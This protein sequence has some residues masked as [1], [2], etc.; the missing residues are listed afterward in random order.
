MIANK[1]AFKSKHP[2]D[3]KIH[4]IDISMSSTLFLPTNISNHF[5]DEKNRILVYN[6]SCKHSHSPRLDIYFEVNPLDRKGSWG[7]GNGMFLMKK[8]KSFSVWIESIMRERRTSREGE[9]PVNKVLLIHFLWNVVCACDLLI[10]FR[11]K[12]QAWTRRHQTMTCI[13]VHER[14]FETTLSPNF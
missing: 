12:C 7:G 11:L 5:Q 3:S 9:N 10:S 8:S 4:E 13:P 14:P 2:V 1:L 6:T